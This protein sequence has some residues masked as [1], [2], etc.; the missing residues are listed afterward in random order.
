MK[1]RPMLFVTAVILLAGCP[2]VKPPVTPLS[3]TA[4]M[5]KCAATAPTFD[6]VCAGVVT[7]EH[8]QC[9]KCP[10]V[11]GCYDDDDQIYCVQG[12]CNDPRCAVE[13]AGQ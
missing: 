13:K 12:S 6:D 8:R 5:P 2:V 3:T 4:L 1:L 10:D 9:F 7:P 11:S